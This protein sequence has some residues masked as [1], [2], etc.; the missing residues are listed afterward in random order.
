MNT[1]LRIDPL[2]RHGGGRM[3]AAAAEAARVA[4]E[5]SGTV[6]RTG[7]LL[8]RRNPPPPAT[9]AH[10]PGSSGIAVE[11]GEYVRL[12]A[13]GITPP[14]LWRNDET[15]Y[16]V[17]AP[18]A[19]TLADVVDAQGGTI[20]QGQLQRIAHIINSGVRLQDT[21]ERYALHVFV[22]GTDGQIYLIHP[23]NTG[24][25][26]TG[27]RRRRDHNQRTLAYFQS[28]AT[29]PRNRRRSPRRRNPRRR[30]PRRRGPRD[31]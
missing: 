20:T 16:A 5:R 23:T 30:S 11:M 13:L 17:V 25:A 9:A 10:A 26:R 7:P 12:G 8:P 2:S 15:G 19:R 18:I 21:H 29:A 1:R 22:E 14:L 3:P 6:V 24:A 27:R 4:E 31:K 28:L